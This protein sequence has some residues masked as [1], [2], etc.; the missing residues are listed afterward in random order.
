MTP[1]EK[2]KLKDML[3]QYCIDFLTERL[4]VMRL[5]II[6][7]QE[8][9]NSEGKSS[10]GDKYET[11]RS[12]GQLEKQMYQKQ[13]QTLLAGL[14]TAESTDTRLHADHVTRGSLVITPQLIVFVCAGLGKKTVD[15]H[16]VLFISHDAPLY[17]LLQGKK[18]SDEFTLN[19]LRHK[20]EDLW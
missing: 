11:G 4:G 13:E 19:N 18:V 1:R 10:A 8:G 2:D 15:E 6:R 9:A 16:T 7:A 14:A 20:I 12:M 3:K 5:L 17:N